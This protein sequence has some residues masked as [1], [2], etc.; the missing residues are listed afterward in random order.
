MLHQREG[1]SFK[2]S[3]LHEKLGMVVH[4]KNP[5]TGGIEIG[6]TLGLLARLFIGKQM[7]SSRLSESPCADQFWPPQ[8][9]HQYTCSVSLFLPSL[10]KKTHHHFLDKQVSM[11][12][13]K[14]APRLYCVPQIVYD[15]NLTW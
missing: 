7:V 1:L 2:S 15:G 9:Q 8:T 5:S 11:N 3:A 12:L 14:K 10:I 6:R 4:A 13:K